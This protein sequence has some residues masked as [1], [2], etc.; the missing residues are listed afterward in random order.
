MIKVTNW[1][2]LAQVPDSETH[3]IEVEKYSGWIINKTTG[4]KERYLSTHTFYGNERES[5]TKVLRSFGFDVEICAPEKRA[6][7]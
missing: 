7:N 1:E 4:D 6:I 2:E 3:T 5:R